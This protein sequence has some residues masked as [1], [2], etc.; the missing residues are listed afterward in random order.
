VD[1]DDNEDLLFEFVEGETGGSM[2]LVLW[3]DD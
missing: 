2:M 3:M 1:M